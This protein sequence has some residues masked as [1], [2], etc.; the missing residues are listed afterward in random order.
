MSVVL[1]HIDGTVGVITLNRPA[2]MNA[3][4]IEMVELIS[5]ALAE[6][7]ASSRVSIIV[8]R[9]EGERAFCAGGDVVMLYHDAKGGGCDGERFWR[10]EYRLN[11]AI[12]RC[13]KPIVAFMHGIVLGGGVGLSGHASHRIVTD[14]TRIG[15][16]EVGIGFSPDVGGTYLLSHAPGHLG[17][18]LALTGAHVGPAEAL[19]AG[20]G[21]VY[22]PSRALPQL[23]RQLIEHGNV[24]VIDSFAE[25]LPLGFADSYDTIEY[26]YDAA[27]VEDILANLDAD[28][29]EFAHDAAKRIRRGCCLAL[30]VAF[31]ALEQART[32]NLAQALNQEFRTSLNMQANPNFIEGVR[33]QL[34]DKDRQPAW[35][36]STLDDVSD[37]DVSAILGP[38]ADSRFSDLGLQ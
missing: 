34:I 8:L 17:L 9:G 23:Y 20:L 6:F 36:P 11:L 33:A 12:S 35:S 22:V 14:S 31:R 19:R 30:K 28:G 7:E 15:M 25:A 10:A 37:A 3:L 5:E 18:H 2:A 26:C 24:S 21:D 29:S 1:S 32:M 13:P 16:P 27:S 4:T 38:I